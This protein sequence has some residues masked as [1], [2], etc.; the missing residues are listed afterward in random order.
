MLRLLLVLEEDIPVVAGGRLLILP[1]AGVVQQLAIGA[2]LEVIDSVESSHCLLELSH[3]VRVLRE[4][5]REL[6]VVIALPQELLAFLLQLVHVPL[7]QVQ[8]LQ[9]LIVVVVNHTLAVVRCMLAL[10]TTRSLETHYLLPLHF[11]IS[12]AVVDPV[13]EVL[14]IQL[15]VEQL[16]LDRMDRVRRRHRVRVPDLPNYFHL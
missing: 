13:L 8:L 16:L 9:P 15:V 10:V 11:V 2:Q 5:R 4:H 3:L 6:R 14:L 1:C 12:A 7:V